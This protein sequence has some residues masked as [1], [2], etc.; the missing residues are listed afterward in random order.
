MVFAGTSVLTGRALA[1]VISTGMTKVSESTFEN[2]ATLK[3]IIIPSTVTKIYMNT[4]KRLY[5]ITKV[6]KTSYL[7]FC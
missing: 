6:I 5:V 1:V 7:I 3:Q 4:Y 2:C